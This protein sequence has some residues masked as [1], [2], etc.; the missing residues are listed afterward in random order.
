M[1]EQIKATELDIPCPICKKG[2]LMLTGFAGWQENPAASGFDG[3]REYVC[4]NCGRKF[5][6]LFTTLIREKK[7]VS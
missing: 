7:P 2:K 4:D 3:F 1:V 6:S 5:K